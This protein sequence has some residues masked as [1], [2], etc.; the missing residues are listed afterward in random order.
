MSPEQLR[1]L[2]AV[3]EVD[4]NVNDDMNMNIQIGREAGEENIDL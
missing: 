3:Q 1:T 2:T 4:E